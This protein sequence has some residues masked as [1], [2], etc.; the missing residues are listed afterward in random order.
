MAQNRGKQ[1]EQVIQQAFEKVPNTSV[2]RLHDQTTGYRGSSNHCDFIVYHKPYEFHIECKS[3]HGNTLSIFSNPKPDKHAVLHGFYGNITDTQWEGL[4][5]KSKIPGVIAGVICWWIDKDV[6]KF[7]PIQML[8]R[9][10]DKTAKSIR[11]DILAC[12]GYYTIEIKGKKKRVFFDYN[13]EEFL[14]CVML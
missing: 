4:L 1:F 9:M 12:G 11:Y 6:T 14:Q 13:M 8:Q 3:V 10:K 2:V 7:I 5:E